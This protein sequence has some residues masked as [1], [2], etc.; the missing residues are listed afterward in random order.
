MTEGEKYVQFTAKFRRIGGG[1]DIETA[2]APGSLDEPSQVATKTLPEKSLL[3]PMPPQCGSKDAV[4][5]VTK[6]DDLRSVS[7][8]FRLKDDAIRTLFEHRFGEGEVGDDVWSIAVGPPATHLIIALVKGAFVP[9]RVDGRRLIPVRS[10]VTGDA[11]PRIGWR[12][13]GAVSLLS[14]GGRQVIFEQDGASGSGMGQQIM[15]IFRLSPDGSELVEI[16]AG[17]HEY[18]ENDSPDAEGPEVLR[19]TSYVVEDREGQPAEIVAHRRRSFG[20]LSVNET[21]RYTWKGQAFQ[22]SPTPSERAEIE[23]NTKA[24][25][26]AS[27]HAAANAAKDTQRAERDQR[28]ELSGLLKRLPT[29]ID[30]CALI[31]KRY[32]ALQEKRSVLTKKGDLNGINS[33]IP[34]LHSTEDDLRAVR[35]EIAAAYQGLSAANAAPEVLDAARQSIGEKCGAAR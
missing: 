9:F 18:N 6:F 17:E 27:A 33:L 24:L 16:F 22:E 20:K 13:A 3:L 35:G 11:S 31:R 14:D 23:K 34:Q 30:R 28:R 29:L 15:S 10:S 5:C 8:A 26:T 25:A 4:P 2:S 19:T 12:L 7:G 21:T 32:S 1:Q